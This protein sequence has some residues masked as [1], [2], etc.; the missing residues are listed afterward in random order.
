MIG[1]TFARLTVTA[2]AP[3]YIDG[4]GRKRLKYQCSCIC[5]K[6]VEVLGENLRSGHTTSCGCQQ[7]DNGRSKR[8]KDVIGQR[9]GRLTI[10]ADADPYVSPGGVSLRQVQ[11]ECEC[12]NKVVLKL[13]SLRQGL[14]AS[15]G[16]YRKELAVSTV[17]HGDARKGKPTRE[18]KCWVGMIARCE[19]PKSTKYEI[20]GGRGITVCSHWREDFENF[21][22]DMGRKPTLKHSIDRIDV[23]GNYEP[24]N[25]R[26]ATDF[27]QANNKRPR[28]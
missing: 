10:L 8:L 23:D 14:S 7:S 13:A 28:A 18:Y 1:K 15:C 5:G 25:C 21:L 6:S 22:A 9:Y 20:Y 3:Q 12:G 16:C 2:K 24:G 19:N 4:S 27:E 11:A 26:W 17:R